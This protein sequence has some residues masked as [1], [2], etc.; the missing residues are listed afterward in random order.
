MTKLERAVRKLEI[1]T[2][3]S[4]EYLDYRRRQ[5]ARILE[6]HEKRRRERG[7]YWSARDASIAG[8]DPSL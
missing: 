2:Q 8:G 5:A 3:R 4:I 1:A 7:S 6:Y